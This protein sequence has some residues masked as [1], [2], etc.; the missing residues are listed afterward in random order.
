MSERDQ[1]KGLSGKRFEWKKVRVKENLN[2]FKKKSIG[3]ELFPS[4]LASPLILTIGI[5]YFNQQ[6]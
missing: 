2:I 1:E 5:D 4:S 3:T 6:K